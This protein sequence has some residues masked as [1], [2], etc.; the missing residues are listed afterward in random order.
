MLKTVMQLC[1]VLV[2]LVT[3]LPCML[4]NLKHFIFIHALLSSTITMVI[5]QC[6]YN[7]LYSVALD[8]YIALSKLSPEVQQKQGLI[9]QIAAVRT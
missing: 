6:N 8:I 2:N 1:A 9:W 4:L 7:H 3:H 5:N